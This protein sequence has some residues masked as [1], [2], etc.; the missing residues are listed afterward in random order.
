M[1][2]STVEVPLADSA[3]ESQKT[4]STS[5]T[6]SSQQDT[7]NDLDSYQNISIAA[8]GSISIIK[9]FVDK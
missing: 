6:N 8:L 3:M 5:N 2:E 4:L 9:K 1:L 7:L